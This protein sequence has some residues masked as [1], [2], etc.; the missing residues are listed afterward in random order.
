MK[1]LSL[2]ILLSSSLS[3]ASASYFAED[4]DKAFA[5]AK[6]SG[7]PI[8]IDFFGIWCPPCNQLNETVFDTPRFHEKSKSFELLQVDVDKEASWKLKD[9]YKVGGYPTILFVNSKG[10]EMYRFVGYREPNEVLKIMD[11]VLQAKG[12]SAKSACTGKSEDDQWRCAVFCME[13][14]DDKCSDK[15]LKSLEGKL[16]PETARY[17]IARSYAAEHA[18]TKD[19]KVKAFESLLEEYPKSPYGLYWGLAYL[20]FAAEQKLSPKKEIVDKMLLNYTAAQND[21]KREEMGVTLTDMAQMRAELLGRLER[22]EESKAAWKE[23]AELFAKQTKDL[24]KGASD[25]GYMIERISCLDM[26]G[27]TDQALK[28][29][30]EYQS[31]YPKEFTFHYIAASVLDRKKR[32]NEAL[33]I[34][35]KAFDVSY[36]DNRIRAGTLLVNLYATVPNKE[37]AK[38]IYDEV[39]KDIKPNA[40]LEV[41]TH[42]YLKQLDQSWQKIGKG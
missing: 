27:E 5:D 37:E 21:P 1:A 11:T 9:K 24:P 13:R 35:K 8:L 3:L 28:L 7:K 40:K 2:V 22:P 16:K 39:K 29:A 30:A 20:N 23:A 14:K 19:L 18:P 33:P 15:A 38:K 12:K 6:K 32:Y 34:A 26:A 36:G 41:R 17:E 4:G 42:R 31:K 25:R 10:E